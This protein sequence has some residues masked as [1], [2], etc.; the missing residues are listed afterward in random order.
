MQIYCILHKPRT[1]KW[2]PNFLGLNSQNKNS[3]N[4]LYT[5]NPCINMFEYPALIR[6]K[7]GLD[8]NL[9]S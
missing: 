6:R 4:A 2:A 3:H 1:S 9:K 7:I 8:L 5:P